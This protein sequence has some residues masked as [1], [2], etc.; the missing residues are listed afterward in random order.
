M[1]TSDIDDLDLELH[2]EI[3]LHSENILQTLSSPINSKVTDETV[4]HVTIII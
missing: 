2:Y 1:K 3:L 4:E